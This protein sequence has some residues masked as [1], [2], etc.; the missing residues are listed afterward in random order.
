MKTAK[1]LSE[2]LLRASELAIKVS[3]CRRLAG[4]IRAIHA[5]LLDLTIKERETLSKACA[6]LDEISTAYDKAARLRK[7]ADEARAKREREVRAAMKDNFDQLATTADKVALIAA[8][9]SYTFPYEL[10]THHD[11]TYLLGAIFQD[12]LDSVAYAVEADA[13]RRAIALPTAL[14]EA[15]QRFTERRAALQDK[16]AHVIVRVDRLLAT[17]TSGSPL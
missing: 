11:A 6:L 2:G 8:A 16:H 12:C 7:C 17:A 4:G 13:Q 10:T 5:D 9:R 1:A 14:A 15:W 3:T